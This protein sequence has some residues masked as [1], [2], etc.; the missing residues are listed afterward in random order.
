MEPKIL[1]RLSL[2]LLL[3]I[4]VAASIYYA[5]SMPVSFDEA[6]TFLNFTQKGFVVSATH[7]PAP[8]N[9]VLH[10]LVTNLTY[11]LPGFSNLIKLR[12]SSVVFNAMALLLLYRFTL[13]NFGLRSAWLVTALASVLFLNVYYSYMSRGYA[14]QNLC[15]IGALSAAFE[16][17]KNEKPLRPW[18]WFGFFSILGFYVMPSF[19]YPFVTLNAYILFWRY[20]NIRLQIMINLCVALAVLLLYLP[21]LSND[22]IA[23]LTQNPYVKPVGLGMTAKSLPFLYLQFPAEITGWH[24][25]FVMLPAIATLALLVKNKSRELLAFFVIF[26]AAPV[27]LLLLHRVI[28][29]ARVFAY[30]GFILA[31]LLVVP[32]RKNW[33]QI[34]AAYLLI[35][36]IGLQLLLVFNF[37]RKINAYE[38][39]DLAANITAAQIIPQIAGDKSYFFSFVLLES[40]LEFEL[41]SR[42]YQYYQIKSV[43]S[44]VDADTIPGC[45]YLFIN[46]SLDRTQNRKKWLSTPYY[47]VYKKN[48]DGR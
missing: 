40:N 12:I 45:D 11:H 4:P 10:S 29:F 36:A 13:R 28:P 34:P 31:L 47:N 17:I 43:M 9:H 3:L 46:P 16:I 33:Q 23:A 6:W 41:I 48:Q 18:L 38:N 2:P 37:D 30:Y 14:L 25:M 19:L 7:Y 24:W 26:L 8:N 15:F 32:Y 44:P 27:V 21:I 22:G 1:N 35:G 20:R 5:L 42:G 39:K